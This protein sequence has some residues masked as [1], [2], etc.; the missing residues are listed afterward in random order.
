MP[1]APVHRLTKKEIVWLGTHRCEAHGHTY[2]EHYSCYLREH[3]E[4]NR[5]GF[6]DIETTDLNAD[7]GFIM[8]YCILDNETGE[9]IG[10]L[11]KPKEIRN[12]VFDKKLVKQLINDM[13]K[14]D[15]LVTF[16]GTRFDL[17]FIRSR[18]VHHGYEFPVYGMINHL[19]VYYI[20]RNKFKLH[21]SSLA[22]A[23][24]FL[25]GDTNKTRI[26]GDIWMKATTGNKKA[27]E[28]VY[29]HNKYDVIDLK[30]LYDKVIDF[31]KRTDRSM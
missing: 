20:I 4:K 30:R 29:E 26:S 3:P 8:S 19:D 13:K 12:G 16:Y 11:I 22:T 25:L 23:T 1:I 17:P 6:L 31:K 18:A 21:R 9:I 28:Y 10:R 2:L 15:T 5:I 14:F 24:E 27:L 7:Y